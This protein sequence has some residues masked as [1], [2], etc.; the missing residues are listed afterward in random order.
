MACHILH[1]IVLTIWII[2]WDNVLNL[3][4]LGV[5]KG[6]IYN[7]LF[8]NLMCLWT[9]F[10]HFSHNFQKSSSVHPTTRRHQSL[11]PSCFWTCSALTVTPIRQKCC[12]FI[13]KD[14]STP[15][16][17]FCYAYV[18]PQPSVI[19]VLISLKCNMFCLEQKVPTICPRAC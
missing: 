3:D 17:E 13:I 12:V 19:H 1:S 6:V 16:R 5:Q 7:N 14:L 18:S 9:Y 2:M 10:L 8:S 15:Y 11:Y 4:L